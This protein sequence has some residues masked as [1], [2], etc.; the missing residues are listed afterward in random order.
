MRDIGVAYCKHALHE[1]KCVESI[2]ASSH[3]QNH[4]CKHLTLNSAAT[5]KY[6]VQFGR[7]IGVSQ[8]TLA[9]KHTTRCHTAISIGLSALRVSSHKNVLQC[10]SHIIGH[11]VISVCLTQW[12]EIQLYFQLGTCIERLRSR[13]IVVARGF[14]CNDYLKLTQIGLSPAILFNVC[15]QDITL[16]E[17]QICSASVL[18]YC[19][20]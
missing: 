12:F 6:W 2:R 17:S 7:V 5:P 10:V 4:R 20:T 8:S 19:K 15:T 3:I 9:T 16:T 18:A 14:G 13:K 11:S 1:A